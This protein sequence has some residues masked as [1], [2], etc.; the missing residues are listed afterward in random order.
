MKIALCISGEPRLYER[1]L[2][3]VTSLRESCNNTDIELHVFYHFWDNITKNVAYQRYKPVLSD[4]IIRT[5]EPEYF[6]DLIKP[7]KGVCE[8]KDTADNDILR[9]FKYIEKIINNHNIINFPRFNDWTKA[10]TDLTLFSYRVKNTN[11][12]ALSQI[13]SFL[14]CQ[15]LRTE[16]EIEN[17]VNFDLVIKT[18]SDIII[19]PL[20]AKTLKLLPEKHKTL[21]QSSVYFDNI[22]VRKEMLWGEPAFF[23]FSTYSSKKL[24]NKPYE[25]ILQEIIELMF[26]V[27]KKKQLLQVHTDHKILP[28]IFSRN[29]IKVIAPLIRVFRDNWLLYHPK[30]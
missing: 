17:N 9:A 2:Q 14:R 12:P 26:H 3:T 30:I 23:T 15:K 11:V 6:L 4:P 21:L 24:F 1:C 13:I 28:T 10:W 5:Y 20:K 27:N 29:N 19:N 7:S 22:Q 16:Y 25:V 18:R 8:G